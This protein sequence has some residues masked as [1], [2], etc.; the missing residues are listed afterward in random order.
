MRGRRKERKKE[1][2]AED[3]EVEDCDKGGI[4][5]TAQQGAKGNKKKI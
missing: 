4:F 1:R 2:R 3:D 5:F